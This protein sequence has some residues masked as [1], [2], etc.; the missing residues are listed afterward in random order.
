MS[1]LPQIIF[2]VPPFVQVLD[3][4]GP[5][6]VFYEAADYGVT[7]RLTYCS[8]QGDVTSATGL[9]FT[10][11]LPFERV[12]A[13]PGDLV[14]VP[15]LDHQYVQSAAFRAE[16]QAFFAWLRELDARGVRLCAV[17]TGAFLLAEAG[18]LDGRKCTT[19]WKR[20]N[21]FQATYPTVL[22]QRDTLFVQDGTIYTSAGITAGIDLALY[23]LEQQHGPL[24]ATQVARE[25]VVYTRRGGEHPQTSI[26]LAYRNHLS[27]GVHQVQDWL[28][29]NLARGATLP[30][31]AEVANMSARNLTRTFR[32]ETGLTIHEYTTK[33]RLELARTLAYDPSLTVEA[34]AAR[35]G[36]QNARQLRR[37]QRQTDAVGAN[38]TSH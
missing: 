38:E 3:L 5:L 7:Y 19:H 37:I 20:L 1:D 22:A 32:K 15:G 26:Y 34:I 21:E 27:S 14:F 33:L 8:Y 4:T 2:T 30:E 6:Q 36:L 11:L 23:L 13:E 16:G 9:G 12:T 18:L 31:L 24:F 25:L 10:Q 29:A 35:C 28:I 17:C